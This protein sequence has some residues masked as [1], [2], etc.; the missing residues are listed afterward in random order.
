MPLN[1]NVKINL[2][3]EELLSIYHYIPKILLGLAKKVSVTEESFGYS[4]QSSIVFTEARNGNYLVIATEDVNKSWLLPR[5]KLRINEFEYQTVQSLFDCRGYQLGAVNKFIAK[6]PA[7]VSLAINGQDWKLEQKGILEFGLASALSQESIELEQVEEE[8]QELRSEL[9]VLDSQLTKI[10]EEYEQILSRFNQSEEERKQLLSSLEL[11][12]KTHKEGLSQLAIWDNLFKEML[13]ILQQGQSISLKQKLE[14]KKKEKVNPPRTVTEANPDS[15]KKNE[16]MEKNLDDLL[17]E[18]EN[19]KK[20]NATPKEFGE[21]TKTPINLPRQENPIIKLIEDYN[22]NP[23]SIAKNAI[24]VKEG[25][26]TNY[27]I[28]LGFPIVMIKSNINKGICWVLNI[29]NSYYLVP[30]NNLKL[31]IDNDSV[32]DCLFILQDYQP[33]YSRTFKLIKPATLVTVEKDKSW[34]VKEKGELQFMPS[35]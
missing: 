32:L 8:N 33:K 4:N 14:P 30:K 25:E 35:P 29:N 27:L 10:K 26:D 16:G 22:S 7:I 20:N 23:N 11:L 1:E 17:N 3:V 2:S 19:I 28:R 15:H 31:N 34:Q 21:S 9:E 13:K 6:K 5:A 24:E 18:I 12:A